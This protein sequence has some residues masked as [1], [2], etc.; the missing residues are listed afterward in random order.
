MSAQWSK[1]YLLKVDVVNVPPA[2]PRSEHRHGMASR[3]DW[4]CRS[5]RR[6]PD[7]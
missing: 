5:K 2:G 7:S 3:Y 6:P 1:V 4:C